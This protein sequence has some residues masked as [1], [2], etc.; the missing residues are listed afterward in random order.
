MNTQCEHTL[1]HVDHDGR[2]QGTW[3]EELVI[4]TCLGRRI[5]IV[6]GSCG[7]FYGYLR[8]GTGRTGA[9]GIASGAEEAAEAPPQEQ[10]N[11]MLG[12]SE[13]AASQQPEA[14][15]PKPS[16]F[17]GGLDFKALRELVSM[18]DVLELI[19]YQPTVRQGE[20]LRGPC[21][22]H[23]SA[24]KRSRTFSVD[25]A[26]NRFQC[27]KPSCGVKG[28]QLDLW[29]AVTEKTIYD[30]ALDLCDRLGIDPPSRS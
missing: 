7:K 16:P 4:D 13:K 28:N 12:R 27:F 29:V 9:P 22:V 10:V 15:G 20:Q 18:A 25:V 17:R 23:G 8:D 26:G 6:C 24:S 11:R 19:R 5:R 21:P 1:Y 30:A 3:T 2:L 14:R